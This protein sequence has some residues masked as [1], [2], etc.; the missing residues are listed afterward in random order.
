MVF[1]C[2]LLLLSLFFSQTAAASILAQDAVP[3]NPSSRLSA[4]HALLL[5][6]SHIEYCAGEHLI[7]AC[8]TYFCLL[9]PPETYY[10]TYCINTV[11]CALSHCIPATAEC[12]ANRQDCLAG[13]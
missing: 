8:A 2:V 1:S 7:S 12:C 3:A 9:S 5:L 13:T 6:R 11:C 10:S 4:K